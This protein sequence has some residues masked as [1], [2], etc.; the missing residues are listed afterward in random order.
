VIPDP[1]PPDRQGGGGGR[2]APRG[3]EPQRPS[4]DVAWV[5]LG[6]NLGR[7]TA[8]LAALRRELTRGSVRLEAASRELLTRAVGVCGQPDFHNQVVRLRAPTS[9][10]AEAWLEHC[11]RAALAA[12]RRTTYRWG[13]RRADADVL[14]LGERGEVRIDRPGLCVPHPRLAERPFLCALLAELDPTLR[15]PDGRLL[16]GCAGIFYMGSRSAS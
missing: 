11:E 13:P 14:L 8:A 5:G 4:S 15:L 1:P 3:R 10:R 9:W 6:T 7:R 16:V 2:A 12:G